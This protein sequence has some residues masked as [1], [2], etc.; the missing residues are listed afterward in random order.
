MK[1]EPVDC[2][3]TIIVTGSSSGIGFAVANRMLRDGHRVIGI[4]RSGDD[5]LLAHNNYEHFKVD[6]QEL[7]KLPEKLEQLIQ[8]FKDVN[9]IVFCAGRGQFGCLEEFSYDQ[10]RSLVDLNFISQSFLAKAY[11]PIFKKRNSGDFIFIGSESALEGSRKGAIYCATKFALR[12]MAQALRE[13]CSRNNIRVAII[14][15][16][17]VNSAFFDGLD[18]APGEAPENYLLPEDVAEAVAFILNS[19]ELTNIDEINLNPM[20]HVVQKKK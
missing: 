12:G 14:N 16:G 6:L 9:G 8:Q 19:R 11:I 4:S 20:K 2:Q 1:S 15:P 3:K 17:M 10:I 5:N 18:F 7:D 13:E